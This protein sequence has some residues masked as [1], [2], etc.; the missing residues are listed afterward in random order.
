M[1]SD[2]PKIQLDRSQSDFCHSSAKNIRLLAP[3]GCGKT[4]SLLHRCRELILRQTGKKR[5]PRFLIVTFTRTATAE[6]KDRVA[7]DPYYEPIRGQANITTLNAWG[8]NR[9]RNLSRVSNP[10]LLTTPADLFFAMKNQLHPV[11][12]GN[13]HIEPVVTKPGTGA[14]T[15]MT[16]MDNLKSMGFVHTR[17]ATGLSTKN[18]LTLWPNKDYPG[19]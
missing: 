7:H 15:L 9:I 16:V 1:N 5:K 4:A 14:R 10:R 8:W 11:W 12:A 19:E 2:Y 18:A 13:Q 6:L 3:A 17:D